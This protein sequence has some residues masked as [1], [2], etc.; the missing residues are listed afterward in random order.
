M[1]NVVT[2]LATSFWIESSTFLQV[3]KLPLPSGKISIDLERDG[4]TQA[5]SFLDW[6]FIYVGNQVMHKSLDEFEWLIS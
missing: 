4:T 1:I 2:T 6:I 5:P 3:T